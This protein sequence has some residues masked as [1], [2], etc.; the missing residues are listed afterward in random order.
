MQEY[1][2]L[3]R[4]YSKTWENKV[5]S[6]KKIKEAIE[7]L[8]DNAKMSVETIKNMHSDAEQKALDT[9]KKTLDLAM[10]INVITKYEAEKAEI[11]R[12]EQERKAEEDKRIQEKVSKDDIKQNVKSADEAFVEACNSVDDDM[13]AAFV[14]GSNEQQKEFILKI[15]C[16]E[17]EK[18][19]ICEYIDNIGV[20]YQ[21]VCNG[22]E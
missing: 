16:S 5:T 10:S 20:M 17:T 22:R 13:V 9:F 19:M 3:S 14:T 6:I 1:L 21:E 7:T 8:V 15:Y 12:K 18:D 4:I 2:P 11:L